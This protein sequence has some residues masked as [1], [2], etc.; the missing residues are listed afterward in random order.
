[1]W[2]IFERRVSFMTDAQEL[3]NER[4]KAP[5]PPDPPSPEKFNAYSLLMDQYI[6]TMAAHSPARAHQ[7]IAKTEQL[8]VAAEGLI[9]LEPVD[10]LR[11]ELAEYIIDVLGTAAESFKSLDNVAR[12][13]QHYERAI[14]EAE[15]NRLT[16]RANEYRLKLTELLLARTGNFDRGLREL[17]P[18][19]QTMKEEPP[20]LA[21]VGVMRLLA[22]GYINIGD[23][24]EAG[25]I[26][27]TIQQDLSALGYPAPG[28]G[29][30]E[31]TLGHWIETADRTTTGGKAF[32]RAVL[33]VLVVYMSIDFMRSKTDV[34]PEERDAIF[35]RIESFNE[36]N[37]CLAK[38]SQEIFER[39][40]RNFERIVPPSPGQFTPPAS[41][42]E[43]FQQQ[44]ED[45]N[46]RLF[47]LRG[48]IDANESPEP[49]LAEAKT[50]EEEAR[51][52]K[53]GRIVGVIRGMQGELMLK[54][55]RAA[56]A[57]QAWRESHTIA[58]NAG[59]MGSALDMLTSIALAYAETKDLASLSEVCAEGINLIE[60]DRSNVSPAYQQ[61]AFLQ[62]KMQF[63]SLG[64]SSAYRLGHHDLMLQRMELTKARASVQQIAQRTQGA[65]PEKLESEIRQ[66][67]TELDQTD[68][69]TAIALREKR[70]TLWDLL[71][72]QRAETNRQQ[73][74]SEFSLSEVQ[75]ALNSDEAVLYY[76]WLAP[77]EL[78]VVGLD[79]EKIEVSRQSLGNQYGGIAELIEY[80]GKM[81][82]PVTH[83]ND[84]I[85]AFAYHLIP[86][87]VQAV[88]RGKKHVIVSPHRILHLFPFQ[89]LRYQG[90]YL[91]NRFAISYAPNLTSLL[92]RYP[93]NDATSVLAVG[94]RDFAVPGL[95]LVPLPGTLYEINDLQALYTEHGIEIDLLDET[96][97]SCQ[98][99]HE[100][101]GDGKLSSFRVLHF[102]THGQDVLGDEPMETYLCLQDGLLDGL[103]IAAWNL[104]A[105]LVVLSACHSGK[106]SF[107]GRGLAELPGDE[108]FG[109]QAAFLTAGAR[110]V[111]AALW[112][113]DDNAAAIIMKAFHERL[114]DGILPEFA[115]QGAVLEYQQTVG[116]EYLKNPYYWAPF[117]I[118]SIGRR[119]DLDYGQTT[120]S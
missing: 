95:S 107:K 101:A 89:A 37:N 115:L 117:F 12:A 21:R 103:D 110:R 63:Y 88:L 120:L 38:R 55:E 100:W 2:D 65:N 70:R 39:D 106:R 80:L 46:E 44:L 75:K 18:M 82:R 49:L 78:L 69:D 16:E 83:L 85:N 76:Y 33:G 104:N 68:A 79:R 97:A 116:E 91:V 61:S 50:L 19:R 118:S 35:S 26:M 29:N 66:I 7:T 53:A 92:V 10:Y 41:D 62:N 112:P 86:E 1:M 51:N 57:I 24:F 108:M 27:R 5:P 43:S 13:R 64:V 102:A 94:V 40:Q 54:L 72:I 45:L 71:A 28:H 119:S 25:R 34:S 52:L 105:E 8:L 15:S 84:E 111:V 114:A 73:P 14:R 6:N 56:D 59:Q 93:A 36:L 17:L 31:Q 32:Q 60:R 23:H 98:R 3:V 81:M 4:M 109:L 113:V 74:P 20:S 30:L 48:R 11:P 58:V 87:S 77:G 90:D 42:R 22:E 47:G 96:N 99:L 9:A 67:N